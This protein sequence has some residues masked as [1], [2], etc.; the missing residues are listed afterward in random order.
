MSNVKKFYNINQVKLS[1]KPNQISHS[2]YNIPKPIIF[3]DKNVIL[4]YKNS[5]NEYCKKYEWRKF[6]NNVDKC[7]EVKYISKNLEKIFKKDIIEAKKSGK[8]VFLIHHKGDAVKNI[9]FDQ[10]DANK[11][12]NIL[13]KNWYNLSYEERA[14]IMRDMPKDIDLKKWSRQQWP[15]NSMR[16]AKNKGAMI[17]YIQSDYNYCRYPSIFSEAMCGVLYNSTDRIDNLYYKSTGYNNSLYCV[18]N[19]EIGDKL[20]NIAEQ[21]FNIKEIST[22]PDV[23]WANMSDTFLNDFYEKKISGK[24]VDNKN[25]SYIFFPWETIYHNINNYVKPVQV[26]VKRMFPSSYK[27]ISNGIS[28]E[29][30]LPTSVNVKATYLSDIPHRDGE[31]FLI[32]KNFYVSTWKIPL[33][34]LFSEFEDKKII[35]QM[36]LGVTGKLL[37]NNNVYFDGTYTNPKIRINNIDIT[38]DIIKIINNY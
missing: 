9:S 13:P 25:I 38:S 31:N 21:E 7:M 34:L 19:F 35:A 32:N 18:G 4:T 36:N 5:E 27:I 29:V 15:Y 17:I 30:Y 6:N 28:K 14:N 37:I 23:E 2:N 16:Y 12:Y 1:N 24:D 22:R 10:E 33:S 26:T 8:E 3:K 11:I 20:Q